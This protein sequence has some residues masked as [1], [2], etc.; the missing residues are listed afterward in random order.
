MSHRNGFWK[1]K[2]KDNTDDKDNIYYILALG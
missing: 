1:K 2:K